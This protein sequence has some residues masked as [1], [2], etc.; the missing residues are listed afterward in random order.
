MRCN[1]VVRDRED[2]YTFSFSRASL[3]GRLVRATG[4]VGGVEDESDIAD[5]S[6][7]AN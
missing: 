1:W 2:N 3:I 7:P 6:M 4:A 5:L